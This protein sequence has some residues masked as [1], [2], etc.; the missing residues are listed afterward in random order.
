[1]LKRVHG[2][3]SQQV[4]DVQLMV[5][6]GYR[7]PEY[8][9]RY[10][11]QEFCLQSRAHP[12]LELEQLME[13]IHQFIALPSVAGHPTGGAVDL[14]LAMKGERGQCLTPIIKLF[15]YGFLLLFEKSSF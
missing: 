4:A 2:R 5:V 15:F 1:M 12:E 13:H 11:L 9:E 6:E 7:S 14:T 8:Q 3:L 10:Y